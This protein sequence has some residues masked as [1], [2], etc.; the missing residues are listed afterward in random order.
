MISTAGSAWLFPPAYIRSENGPELTEKVVRDRG[1]RHEL[2]E[3]A[4]QKR[5]DPPGF[6]HGEG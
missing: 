2:N 1:A 6:S 4:Q 3:E 5:R